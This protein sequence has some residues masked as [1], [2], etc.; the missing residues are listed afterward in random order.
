VE[1]TF[2][3]IGMMD[4]RRPQQVLTLPARQLRLLE[5]LWRATRRVFGVTGL[6]LLLGNVALLMAPFPHLHLC[7]FPIALVLGPLLG[8]FA[9]RDRVVLAESRLPCPRCHH[10]LVV[11]EGTRGWPARFNCE[12]CGIMVELNPVG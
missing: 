6:L 11:P 10:T 12:Q 8:W 4:S 7:L 2:V 1:P 3:R 9:W 5:R